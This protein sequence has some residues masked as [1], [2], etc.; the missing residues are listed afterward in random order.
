MIKGKCNRVFII[1]LDFGGQEI[2]HSHMPN[3]QKILS[4]GA[5]THSAFAD[6]TAMSGNPWS[7]LIEDRA[8]DKPMNTAAIIARY[9][10]IESSFYPPFMKFARLM[11]PDCPMS[12]VCLS[13][14]YDPD[15]N[16]DIDCE[17]HIEFF[18]NNV[19]EFDLKLIYIHFES[20]EPINYDFSSPEYER[21]IKGR[22]D[23]VGA[24]VRAIDRAGML[25]D[26]IIIFCTDYVGSNKIH[27]KN[28][29][30]GQTLLWGCIGPG[31][32]PGVQI[33]NDFKFI[34]MAALITNC[35]G[36]ENPERCE[37][38][39]PDFIGHA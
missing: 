26:S 5:V 30:D 3:T 24:I 9:P 15:M 34:D 32:T 4:T 8:Q 17:M 21:T 6:V 13:V 38:R 37:A 10:L 35:L 1:G 31:V 25:D 12:A 23:D 14:G 16:F 27:G 36:L 33:Q 18:L 22:D 11:W 28:I 2:Q 29:P 19:S 39:V 20:S 7:A